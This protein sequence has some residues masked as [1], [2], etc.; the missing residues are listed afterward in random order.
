MLLQGLLYW[1]M[2]LK[3]WLGV[4]QNNKIMAVNCFWDCAEIHYW[5]LKCSFVSSFLS[6]PHDE[7]RSHSP[8]C[9][10]MV[11]L[12]LKNSLYTLRNPLLSGT[13]SPSFCRPSPFLFLS[14]SV[15]PGVNLSLFFFSTASW[16]L[17]MTVCIS[18]HAFTPSITCCCLRH[19][20]ILP[21]CL[22]SQIIWLAFSS[23][24]WYLSAYN[25]IIFSNQIRFTVLL[26][27]TSARCL[28]K[29]FNPWNFSSSFS[30][31]QSYLC[32]WV[33]GSFCSSCMAAI[34]CINTP[35]VSF[36]PNVFLN[37]P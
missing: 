27:V 34:I 4:N 14:P 3:K 18:V 12:H 29:E 35:L 6:L 31:Y 37:S 5:A 9:R 10:R 17:C 11:H 36:I 25:F 8:D 26:K 7:Y 15:W 22:S 13:T 24:H 19:S 33:L 32:W 23:V 16:F 20:S 1:F 2:M 30:S 21:C 28:Q